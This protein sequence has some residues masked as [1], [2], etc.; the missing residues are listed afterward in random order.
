MV[1]REYMKGAGEKPPQSTP[2]DFEKISNSKFDD[3]SFF[4]STV[5]FLVYLFRTQVIITI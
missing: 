4:P 1:D 3:M 5:Y 2:A